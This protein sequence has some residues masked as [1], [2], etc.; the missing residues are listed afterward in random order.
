MSGAPPASIVHPRQCVPP[1][2]TIHQQPQLSTDDAATVP[3]EQTTATAPSI[4]IRPSATSTAAPQPINILSHDTSDRLAYHADSPGNSMGASLDIGDMSAGT[5]SFCAMRGRTAHQPGTQIRTCPIPERLRLQLRDA[6]VHDS[7]DS[8]SPTIAASSYSAQTLTDSPRTLQGAQAPPVRRRG[9]TGTGGSLAR[10]SPKD[11]DAAATPQALPVAHS[12]RVGKAILPLARRT[13]SS[14]SSWSAATPTSTYGTADS[15]TATQNDQGMLPDWESAGQQQQQQ[16]MSSSTKARTRSR[17]Y[18]VFDLAFVNQRP[19]P[20]PSSMQNPPMLSSGGARRRSSDKSAAESVGSAELSSIPSGGR[21]SG[22]SSVVPHALDIARSRHDSRVQIRGPPTDPTPPHV[23]PQSATDYIS[24]QEPAMFSGRRHRHHHR[25]RHSRD[26]SRGS[27]AT[28]STHSMPANEQ[29]LGTD[30][31][32]ESGSAGGANRRRQHRRPFST[33]FHDSSSGQSTPNHLLFARLRSKPSGSIKSANAAELCHSPELLPRT[34]EGREYKGGAPQHMSASH[35]LG[36]SRRGIRTSNVRQNDDDDGY[37]GDVEADGGNEVLYLRFSTSVPDILVMP[38]VSHMGGHWRTIKRPDYSYERLLATSRSTKVRRWKHRQLGPSADVGQ[39]ATDSSSMAATPK[40]SRVM[41]HESVSPLLQLGVSRRATVST[42]GGL[43]RRVSQT[44]S[45]QQPMSYPPAD[46]P[47]RSKPAASPRYAVDPT[48]AVNWTDWTDDVKAESHALAA[49]RAIT[50]WHRI[51][52]NVGREHRSRQ[53]SLKARRDSLGSYLSTSNLPRASTI[54]SA[55]SIQSNVGAMDIGTLPPSGGCVT[56]M[57]NPYLVEPTY[58]QRGV[59][60]SGRQASPSSAFSSIYQMPSFSNL[61]SIHSQSMTPA[62]TDSARWGTKTQGPRLPEVKG[63]AAASAFGDTILGHA[64]AAPHRRLSIIKGQEL[65][66]GWGNLAGIGTS[67]PRLERTEE[68]A[69]LGSDGASTSSRVSPGTSDKSPWIITQLD[70][71]EETIEMLQSFQSRLQL[72]LSK[73]KAE[74]EQELVEIIQDLSEFVEEGLSYVNEDGATYSP[75]NEDSAASEDYCSDVSY[76]SDQDDGYDPDLDVSA[77]PLAAEHERA[78]HAMSHRHS[79]SAGD[80]LAR[81]NVAKPEGTVSMAARELKSLNKHLHDML[82]LHSDSK[83]MHSEAARPTSQPSG[84]QLQLAPSPPPLTETAP[85]SVIAASSARHSP[86]QRLI[87]SPSIR[88]LAF[89]RALAGDRAI[90]SEP[91]SIDSDATKH[92]EPDITGGRSRIRHSVELPSALPLFSGPQQKLSEASLQQHLGFASDPALHHIHSNHVPE[93]VVGRDAGLDDELHARTS[94]SAPRIAHDPLASWSDLRLGAR[95]RSASPQSEIP[96]PSLHNKSSMHSVSSIHQLGAAASETSSLSGGG[97]YSP[98]ARSQS[99]SSMY[100]A[101]SRAS[102]L[103]SPLIAEDEF[104]PTPFLQAIIDL[105]TI[106]G[107]VVSLSASDMLRPLSG[108][109]LEEAMNHLAPSNGDSSSAEDVRHHAMSL[110]PTAYVVQR[111]NELGHLWEQP[112]QSAEES[113]EMA[114]QPWPCRGLFFRALLAISSLNRIVMWYAAVRTTYGEDI[115]AEVDRRVNDQERGMP[116][117]GDAGASSGLFPSVSPAGYGA[118]GVSPYSG[119]GANTTGSLTGRSSSTTSLSTAGP[120]SQPPYEIIANV[121]AASTG[122]STRPAWHNFQAHQQMSKWQGDTV[123]SHSAAAVDKGLNML[124]EITLDGRIRYIS[125]TCQRL[126]GTKPEALINKPAST[127][128][129]ADSIRVCRSAVEQLLADSTRTVEINITV[130]SPDLSRAAMVEAKGMLIYCRARNEPSHV[131]WVLRYAAASPTQHQLVSEEPVG[132]SELAERLTSALPRAGTEQYVEDIVPSALALGLTG[133]DGASLEYADTSAVVPGSELPDVIEEDEVAALSLSPVEY[134]TCRICDRA[135]PAA[136]FEEHNWLCAQSHRAAMDVEQLNE[137]LGDVK[138]E[139]QAWYP[140]CDFEELEDIVHGGTDVETLR[141]H[142]QQRASEVGHPA[143]QSLITKASPSVKSMTKMCLMALALDENDASPKCTHPA[144]LGDLGV[145]ADSSELDFQRSENWVSVAKYTV[146]VVDYRDPALEALGE[147]LI[148]T[149]AAKLTAIDSLQYAIVESSVACTSWVLPKDSSMEPDAFLPPEY[150]RRSTSAIDIPSSSAEKGGSELHSYASAKDMDDMRSRSARTPDPQRSDGLGSTSQQPLPWQQDQY[151]GS[152]DASYSR[153]D[154][155]TSP[156]QGGPNAIP[157][158][159]RRTS[160]QSNIDIPTTRKASGASLSVSQTSPLRISTAN[161][162]QMTGQAPTRPNI[163][164]SAFLATPTVPSIHDFVVLKPISKG[165]YGSVFLAKKRTTGEYYAI[166]IL[167]KADM[168]SKNQISNVKAE[169]AIM[170]AQTGSPFVV[171]LLYTFQ[172]RTS[173]YL[174]MEYLN[175]GDCAALLKAIGT[176][177][178]DWARNYLAEVVLGIEDLHARNVVHRDL[179]PDNLLI[180]SEGHL[181]L[182]D[183]GLSKLGFLGRRVDQHALSH[184]MNANDSALLLG[185]TPGAVT[186]SSRVWQPFVSGSARSARRESTDHLS[187]L[188]NDSSQPMTPMQAVVTIPSISTP[189]PM[190]SEHFSTQHGSQARPDSVQGK[191]VAA[192]KGSPTL[193][194]E[195]GS[196]G[197]NNAVASSSASLSSSASSEAYGNTPAPRHQK[198]ALGTPDYIAPESI[199]G[200][201]SGKSV[202]WWALG[203]ICYEFLFG[204]PPFHDETPEKVFS[205]ILSADIDFYDELREQLKREN[206]EKRAQHE[207]RRALRRQAACSQDEDEDEEG[208]SDDEHE[209]GDSCDDTGVADISSEARDFITRLLCRDPKRRLGYNGAAEVKAHPIFAG[210]DWD[211]LLETQPAFVPHVDD[212]EDTDYFD[213]R[214]ATMDANNEADLQGS[215]NEEADD[216]RR[217]SEHQSGT[218]YAEVE[219]QQSL[220][221]KI[222]SSPGSGARAAKAASK[223]HPHEPSMLHIGAGVAMHRPS[224]VPL[225][226]NELPSNPRDAAYAEPAATAPS[227]ACMP[228]ET[229]KDRSYAD[230]LPALEDSPEF[231]GFTFKNLH[232]LEQANMNEL[233]KLRRRS[234]LLDMS[235]RP[236]ARSEARSSLVPG[237]ATDNLL[238]SNAK[239]HQSFLIGNSS[240][241]NSVHM[242]MSSPGPEGSMFGSRRMPSLDSS[243][244]MHGLGTDRLHLPL[245]AGAQLSRTRTISSFTPSAHVG[246][247]SA[248]D[249]EGARSGSGSGSRVDSGRGRSISNSRDSLSIASSGSPAML[250]TP[251]HV[252]ALSAHAHIH[253]GSLLNPSTQTP[254]LSRS[255]QQQRQQLPSVADFAPANLPSV[256]I[257]GK[258]GLPL[259]PPRLAGLGSSLPRPS[260]AKAAS[261][262]LSDTVASTAAPPQPDYMQSRICLVADD[263]PVCLKIMEIILRRLHME[264]V[265]VRNGAEAIRCAMGRTVFRAIFMDTGMP[266]VD[267]D[268]ATRMIKSTYNANKDTPVIAMAAYDGEAAGELY[269]DAIVKPVTFHH[270]KQSLSRAS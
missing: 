225:R 94:H 50:M 48:E 33:G 202:D 205:N 119:D 163:G 164:S 16:P 35:Q 216:N 39:P 155:G 54:F 222:T 102:L 26:Q 104:K 137:R 270:V 40:D 9:T 165:A 107:H 15:V 78:V 76:V 44:C 114:D 213:T 226:L 18:S 256:P 121:N 103:A 248:D 194:H 136:Y 223:S 206:E 101:G 23:Y 148:R 46:T 111:L 65:G 61:D 14:Y 89:L 19:A 146:P 149:I 161:L 252:R 36:R 264:C 98:R 57:L 244:H 214:G 173:L 257:P 186:T 208:D 228:Q 82:S 74:S 167:K 34:P 220:A 66:K 73:A 51:S 32:N 109:L 229:S 235:P 130:H 156:R 215:D 253:R 246:P 181:K 24:F 69:S 53:N 175:G 55:N 70:D 242:E 60:E 154:V 245:S 75:Y 135:I 21:R 122:D 168:I 227:T 212:V 115:V 134:I 239:R 43:S 260:L 219:S 126:L 233:V 68:R 150:L 56:A 158:S 124:V 110:M 120:S 117:L 4:S 47:V 106:I 13:S 237:L 125:P 188:D 133:V 80:Q 95:G 203:I 180:D 139:L 153:A 67:P 258:P 123:S 62:D 38:M 37:S 183:F 91:P 147:S 174:V 27:I 192:L 81:T 28:F 162:H 108:S 105:V 72:R 238:L 218:S 92:V 201:E 63:N 269:D 6:S 25:H 241:R 10:R 116:A 41:S 259:P 96:F 217:L 251:G 52:R 191:R 247:G 263:N 267:G 83:D 236:F 182:T 221:I 172:S 100:S 262:E 193:L 141:E 17:R 42:A 189:P 268:E 129:T 144:V 127:I 5:S 243:E 185:A 22:A 113:E 169:R 266:I 97:R 171:R 254:T 199:L 196:E 79:R 2:E 88:R 187:T 198:H 8:N 176:L 210:I 197:S 184:P 265:I 232:A 1:K 142:A 77:M 31:D 179:K 59:S 85:V 160:S 93:I 255:T 211:T 84:L 30:I 11:L 231:G 250:A 132:S 166:K 58:L 49:Q 145:Q 7:T 209:D 190:R 152:S 29:Q 90:V 224:T 234:T 45:A 86:V 177:S 12:P 118:V 99:R 207:H 128:F 159:S 64:A 230:E 204:I 170:M 240:S 195:R 87:R 157:V 261:Y 151:G 131:M 143:W 20:W 140:G 178:E 249:G 71:P 138:A 3:L 112:P 200:L